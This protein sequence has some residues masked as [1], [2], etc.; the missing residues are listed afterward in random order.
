M[1]VTGIAAMDLDGVI[2]RG[3][4]LPWV[5]KRDLGWFRE[6]TLGH[7]VIMGRRTFQSLEEPLEG[8]PNIILTRRPDL[9][10]GKGLAAATQFRAMDMAHAECRRLGVDEVFVIGGARVFEETLH[11]W[12]RALLTVIHDRLG[13]DV[14]F[15]TERF[16]RETWKLVSHV[17]LPPDET[18]SYREHRL[19][20]KNVRSDFTL[21]SFLGQ[22][23]D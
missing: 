13:G 23:R 8:R 7:P 14:T 19:E 3:G 21:A 16:E 18:S 22:F 11:W 2:G 6:T 17:D 10:R 5:S 4:G 15:P 9:W 12:G 1:I 20:L